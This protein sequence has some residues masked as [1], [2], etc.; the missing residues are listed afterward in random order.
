MIRRKTGYRI[1][2]S[3]VRIQNVGRTRSIWLSTHRKIRTPFLLDSAFLRT[4]GTVLVLC[5]VLLGWGDAEATGE[6]RK[7]AVAGQ[8]YPTEPGEL[9]GWVDRLLAN[10][11]PAGIEGDVF[12]LISPHAGYRFSGQTAAHGYRQIQGGTFDAV[13]V[14][15]PS[16]RE[17]LQGVSVYSGAGYETPLGVAPVDLDLAEAIVGQDADIRFSSSG[18]RG[19]HSIEAQIP[20]LQRA[21]GDLKIVPIAMWRSDLDLCGRLAQAIVSASKGRRVLVVASSDLYHAPDQDPSGEWY[22]ECVRTDAATLRAIEALDP[23]AFHEGLVEGAYQVCGA[24]PIVTAMFVAREM[25]ADR[26]KVVGRTNSGDVTDRRLGYIVGY[27]SV[28]LYRGAGAME[29]TEFE[30]LNEEAQ[31]DLLRMAREA[32]SGYLV[33]GRPPEF[34][35]I[36]EIF[37]EKRGVFVTL[38][39]DGRLRGCIGYHGN[40]V[41]L[42]KLVPSRAI[43]AAFEDPRFPPIT[44]E[45]VDALH[46]KISVYLDRVHEIQSIDEFEVGKHGIIMMKGNRGATFLPE[47]PVEAGW[48]KEEELRQLCRKAG[49]PSNGWK[50]AT[51]YVYT[52]Q[53]FEEP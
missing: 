8:W 18:H 6:I 15:G 50:D 25:G 29:K 13:V 24:G 36:L 12:A 20:F 26:A 43:A 41:P 37:T 32:I 45:E 48:T 33:T 10:A 44:E 16:H 34:E 3:G 49:L 51:F 2:N 30:P 28:V 7:P 22:D 27:G 35:P 38:T 19:E 47:V 17:R 23:A 11:E 5:V 46:I 39:K 1:Q 31:R 40:D 9:R 42:H 4:I 14:L 53:V 21:L 52:T